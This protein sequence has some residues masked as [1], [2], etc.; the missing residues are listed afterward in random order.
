VVAVQCYPGPAV[1]ALPELQRNPYDGDKSK[2]RE[3]PKIPLR[4]YRWAVTNAAWEMR[5]AD[6]KEL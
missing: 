6:L 3:I 4:E 2:N 5:S 1:F